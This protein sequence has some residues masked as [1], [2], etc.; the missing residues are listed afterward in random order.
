M[1]A[2]IAQVV[3]EIVEWW[4]KWPLLTSVDR[5][6]GLFHMEYFNQTRKQVTKSQKGGGGGGANVPPCPL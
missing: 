3:A 6:L 4:P 2:E 1:V 5:T